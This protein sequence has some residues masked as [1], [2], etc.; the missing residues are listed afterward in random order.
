MLAVGVDPAPA[1]STQLEG[2]D[3][4][5]PRHKFEKVSL[6]LPACCSRHLALRVVVDERGARREEEWSGFIL[7]GKSFAPGSGRRGQRID[8]LYAR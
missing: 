4:Y 8:D 7:N 5:G 6:L 1:A 3:R 2:W